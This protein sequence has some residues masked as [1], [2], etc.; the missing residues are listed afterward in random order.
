[1]AETERGRRKSLIGRVDSDKMDKTVIVEVQ[2]RLMH[3]VYKK[4]VKSRAKYMAH[5][6]TNQCHVGD[7]VEIQEDRP[8]SRN[9][10][11]KVTRVIER[12]ELT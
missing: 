10:R 7:T 2:R 6:E 3:P 4:F 9:K 5:D 11:W 8:R 1:M 12:A